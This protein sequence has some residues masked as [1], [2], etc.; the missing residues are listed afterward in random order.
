MKFGAAEINKRYAE[1]CLEMQKMGMMAKEGATAPVT[2]SS[3]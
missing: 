2:T 3:P 1:F